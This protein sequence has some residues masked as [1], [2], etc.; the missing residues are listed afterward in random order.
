LA[1]GVNRD[2]FRVWCKKNSTG[3]KGPVLF[4]YEKDDFDPLYDAPRGVTWEARS[5][6]R[7]PRGRVITYVNRP[8]VL[9]AHVGLKLL[10]AEPAFRVLQC[11]CKTF[12]QLHK[13]VGKPPKFCPAC[14]EAKRR[15]SDLSRVRKCRGFTTPDTPTLHCR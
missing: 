11:S 7:A 5:L 12:S 8:E 15:P 3:L 14:R 10:G 13:A 9:L 1:G 2:R 4:L 6:T